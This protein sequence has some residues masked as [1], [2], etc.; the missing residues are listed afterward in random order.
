MKKNKNEK[1]SEGIL[2][3]EELRMLKGG[4]V[5]NKNTFSGCNCNYNNSSAVTNLNLYGTCSCTCTGGEASLEI[6]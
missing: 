2:N 4:G 6:C 3:H 5:K 1:K